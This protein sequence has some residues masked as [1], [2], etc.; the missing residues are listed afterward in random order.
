MLALL[1]QGRQERFIEEGIIQ[2]ISI[3][4]L[5]FEFNCFSFF[6]LIYV[7]CIGET[8]EHGNRVNDDLV[9][10]DIEGTATTETVAS[11]VD[12]IQGTWHFL[13]QPSLSD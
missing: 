7:L 1:P 10:E 9:A 4:Q 6:L 2:N 3:I 8:S 11:A 13:T 5:H 12:D